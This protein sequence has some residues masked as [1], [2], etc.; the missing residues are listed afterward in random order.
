MGTDDNY[1]MERIFFSYILLS[2]IIS[3]LEESTRYIIPTIS[4]T[5][6][7]QALLIVSTPEF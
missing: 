1:G 6:L 7:I 5:K 4:D 2:S 3:M